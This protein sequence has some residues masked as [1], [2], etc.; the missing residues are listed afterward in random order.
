MFKKNFRWTPHWPGAELKETRPHT[1][2][3]P[4]LNDGQATRQPEFDRN[5]LLREKQ[6]KKRYNSR[7]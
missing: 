7:T 1:E 2:N 5:R 3:S 4:E 6:K